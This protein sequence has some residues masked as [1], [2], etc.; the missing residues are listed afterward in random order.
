MPSGAT[1]ASDR[2]RGGAAARCLCGGGALPR[3]SGGKSAGEVI[4]TERIAARAKH[5]ARPL[6]RVALAPQTTHTS[7]SPRGAH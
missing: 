3:E 2:Q 7:C 1:S 5:L 4:A 6:N